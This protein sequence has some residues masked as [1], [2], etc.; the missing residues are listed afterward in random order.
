MIARNINDSS[1]D[2][3]T[4]SKTYLW[5]VFLGAGSQ[6][7]GAAGFEVMG[8]SQYLRTTFTG[9]VSELDKFKSR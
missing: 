4:F 7:D 5:L 1:A 8:I 9:F 6:G 3:G 2:A